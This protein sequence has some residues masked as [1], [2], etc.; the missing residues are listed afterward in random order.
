MSGGLR[1]T[2][3]EVYYGVFFHLSAISYLLCLHMQN[4]QEHEKSECDDTQSS[5]FRRGCSFCI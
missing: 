2:Y 1:Q 5:C 3:S 4:G